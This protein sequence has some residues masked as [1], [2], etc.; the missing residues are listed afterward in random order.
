[1]SVFYHNDDPLLRQSPITYFQNNGNTNT[2][3]NVN[4]TYAQL[5]KQQLMMEMQQQHQNLT[6]KDWLGDLDNMMKGLDKETVE[7]LNNNNDFTILN[8]QLQSLIQNELMLLVKYKIN[9]NDGAVDN[10]KKQMDIMRNMTNQVKEQEKQNIN[11]LNDYMKNYS[12]L[13][14]DEYRKLKNGEPLTEIVSTNK[15]KKIKNIE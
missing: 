13:T 12:H 5:Y 10:I 4:D 7:L 1:M 6:P 8:T 11:E 15:N 14:F 9:A 2:P 3:N